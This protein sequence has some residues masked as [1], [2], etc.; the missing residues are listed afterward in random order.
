MIAAGCMAATLA[1]VSGRAFAE[2]PTFYVYELPDGSRML[3]NHPLGGKHYKLVRVG[4]D[5]RGSGHLA[6]ASDA[7]IF[8]AVPSTYDDMIRNISARHRV[9][10][11]LVKA[12]MHVESGFNPYATSPRGAHGLMQLMPDTA[13]RHGVSDITDPLQNIEGG[14]R[15]IKYLAEQFNNKQYLIIAAYNAGENAVRRHNGIP[16]YLETQAYVRKVMVMRR[17]Y[18]EARHS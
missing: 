9:D 11:A 15:Y 18:A 10:F 6:V 7:Q 14:V 4:T 16:P 17:R 5:A 1:A 13:R 12:I 3:S 2:P 8:R